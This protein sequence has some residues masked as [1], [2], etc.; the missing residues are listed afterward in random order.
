MNLPGLHLLFW[1]ITAACNLRCRHCRR[2]NEVD[3]PL[4]GEMTTEEGKRFLEDVLRIARPIIVFSGGE[5]TMRQDLFELVNHASRLGMQT[6]LATNGT[7]I[8]PT[9]A[10]RIADSPIKRVSISFDGADSPT[11]DSFRGQKGAFKAALRG[12]K[13]LQKTKISLQVNTTLSKHNLH[14]LPRLYELAQRLK[15]DAV[16]FFVVISV[17]CGLGMRPEQFLSAQ[18][19]EE[20]L[21]WIHQQGDIGGVTAKPTCAPQFFRILLQHRRDSAIPPHLHPLPPKGGEERMGHFSLNRGRT[22]HSPLPLGERG[23]VRGETSLS[24]WTK[25]CLAGTGIGFV[26]SLG[27]VF[28]CGYLPIKV[29]NVKETPFDKIWQESLVLKQLRDPSLLEG[30]C[31]VCS[32]RT[33]CGGCRARAWA[34]TQDVLAEDPSCVYQP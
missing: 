32:Y 10:H 12:W 13:Y 19:I 5:P 3:K 16:H 20:A 31:G 4:P 27:D 23:R 29:G 17:G 18:E 33:I 21:E 11:H 15:A 22:Q 28:P 25:G 8:D 9:M 1:E 30:K 14:Q 6:A 7:S 34:Q 2:L 24:R 26:S